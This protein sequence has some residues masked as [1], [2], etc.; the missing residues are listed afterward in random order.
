M[1]LTC[2]LK[3]DVNFTGTFAENR[4]SREKYAMYLREAG[5]KAKFFELE[6]GTR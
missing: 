4:R 2:K 5:F 6:S 3:F 1:R